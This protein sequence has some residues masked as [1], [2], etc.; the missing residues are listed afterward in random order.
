[1]LPARTPEGLCPKCLL[2]RGL[3]LLAAPPLGPDAE[4][5]A[6]VSVPTTPFTGTRLR[7]FG[8]YEL[9]EE[10]ARGGM[11]VVFKARQVSLNRVVALKLISAGTLATPE[12][13]KRFK[14]EAEAAASLTHPNIVPIHEIGEHQGQ[15]YFSM[16]L[17]EGPNLRDALAARRKEGNQLSVISNQSKARSRSLLTDH[18]SLSTRVQLIA[19][20]A[21]A[22]HYAHQRGVLHRDVKP[23]NILLDA[24]GQPHLTDFGLAK[25]VEKE[26]TLTHTYAVLGTPAY[27]APEQARG[28]AKAV[29]TAADV[30][31]LGAVLYEVLTGSPPFAGGTSME[32]IRQ[33]LDE[34]PR[35]PSFWNPAVDGDLETICLK[36]LEKD[37][38]RRY[39]SAGG[40]ADDLDRWL[41]QE[42]I[43][44]RPAT[45]I[46][47]ARK[48]VRRRPAIAALAATSVLL[49]VAMAIG[50]ITWALLARENALQAREQL[51]RT[52][53]RQGQRLCEAGD[54]PAGLLWLARSLRECPARE[55]DL[56]KIIRS[57][58]S[59]W[60]EHS[61]GLQWVLDHEIA[62]AKRAPIGVAPLG[63]DPAFFMH[64]DGKRLVSCA[65]LK[66]TA[67][68]WSLET[69]APV[70]R[71]MPH[72]DAVL[73]VFYAA[74]GERIVTVAADGQIGLWTSTGERVGEPT[75]LGSP[76]DA[77]KKEGGQAPGASSDVFLENV[78]GHPI[79][80]A[81]S[82]PAH[83]WI[84]VWLKEDVC[85]L[86]RITDRVTVLPPWTS[87]V[88]AVRRVEEGD[89]TYVV[90]QFSP[91]GKRLAVAYPD[92]SGQILSLGTDPPAEVSV[93]HGT[94]MLALAFSPDGRVLVTGA[95][96]SIR[97][98]SSE[99]GEPIGQ[100][101][102]QSGGLSDS[103]W[104][105]PH[106]LF[107]P[108]SQTFAVWSRGGV[109]LWSLTND[110][111]VTSPLRDPS[112]TVR[113]MS[114]SPDGRYLITGSEDFGLRVW[115]VA[116]GE[117]VIRGIS[118]AGAAARLEFTP[119]GERLL[120]SCHAGITGASGQGGA[121][122]VRR[123]RTPEGRSKQVRSKRGQVWVVDFHP[124]G[125]QFLV[126]G[127]VGPA[128]IW[129]TASLKLELEFG[130]TTDLVWDAAYSPKG[131]RIVTAQEVLWGL[132]GG[133]N[134]LSVLWSR[135]GKL[136]RVLEHG[137]GINGACAFHP[138]GDV[139][140]IGSW[141]R[142][143]E[144]RSVGT[145][146]VLA[147][148]DHPN[149]VWDLDFHPNGRWL[150]TACVDGTARLWS[151]E[152]TNLVYPPVNH[153]PNG[154]YCAQFSPDGSRFATGGGDGT[155]R[156]WETRTGK[157]TGPTFLHKGRVNDLAFKPDG[158]WLISGGADGTARVWSLAA[159]EELGPPPRHPRS[160]S[161]VAID[162]AGEWILIGGEQ[163][164]VTLWPMAALTAKS[165]R[166][167]LEQVEI[168]T[169][170]RLSEQ[171]TPVRMEY[172]EWEKLRQRH[173]RR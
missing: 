130:E 125:S 115:S 147:K 120:A 86:V 159:G 155:I 143:A 16:D 117:A 34:E 148:F 50:G 152:T 149:S 106:L 137:R 104:I 9:L 60:S 109:Q 55:Q 6:D 102:L 133:P 91:D 129:S 110:T 46:E 76:R 167:L 113:C 170:S 11:G 32:T 142:Y 49:L 8:D 73:D 121:I 21:R 144:V 124:D 157:P 114:F 29:T 135:D 138:Q 22:V 69:G 150:L 154:L 13:V 53:L 44:A 92:G 123:F 83:G 108:D 122:E 40:L 136:L 68:V 25:L 141:L 87:R 17:I 169:G 45:R 78:R 156:L 171:G 63:L 172:P 56:D 111:P 105:R 18:W 58:I 41:R 151:L 85:R 10:I 164:Q 20:V 39:R 93:S 67:Q 80:A 74:D 31:G 112:T 163:P 97:L 72:S 1:V 116:T 96:N 139:V 162:P 33:V 94:N 166:D 100:P 30:Y 140:A 38:D 153:G 37:P 101:R 62:A 4:A 88:P 128:E 59:N 119:D 42:P 27:M 51:A 98:W 95:G 36:C 64:P 2:R 134:E 145:G 161:C 65:R 5:H 28:D 168:L 158:E 81:T 89:R 107:G 79:L 82:L 90:A 14:A 3:E 146:E 48:W 132:T 15:H 35:R 23:G 84:A 165:S 126:A 47:R 7:Y 160:V 66:H 99:T 77:V 103:P 54:T 75:S 71:P 19:T 131:D 43:L 52:Y 57:N 12:L 127:A 26:S 24:A 61:L 70:G 173:V 118:Y